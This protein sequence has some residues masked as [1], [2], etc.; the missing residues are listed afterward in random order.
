[1]FWSISYWIRTKYYISIIQQQTFLDKYSLTSG[2]HFTVIIS[3]KRMFTN[4]LWVVFLF[5]SKDK[6]LRENECLALRKQIE[7]EFQAK[8]KLEDSIL[9]KMRSQLTMDK[10]AKYSKK[11]T[12]KT[13]ERTKHMVSLNSL[14]SWNL[15][16]T[17][18]IKSPWKF[19][20]N[21]EIRK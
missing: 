6:V 21:S 17:K 3:L 8:L 12:G 16:W 13:R 19:Q 15:S 18:E 7:Q 9:E 14:V 20:I 11:L 5:L 1:M 4:L 2:Y 10:A